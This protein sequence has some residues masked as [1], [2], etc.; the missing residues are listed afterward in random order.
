[1]DF[2]AFADF[3]SQCF[4]FSAVSSFPHFPHS[5]QRERNAEKNAYKITLTEP[6][7][8]MRNIAH[9]FSQCFQSSAVSSFPHFPHSNQRERNGEKNAYK[10][11]LTE[12]LREM[13]N[14]AHKN[15]LNRASCPGASEQWAPCAVHTFIL[16]TSG[17]L[18]GNN[19]VSRM[20]FLHRCYFLLE[21][22]R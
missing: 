18:N 14:I 20:H 16:L 8:E 1:M 10:I 15:I 17:V 22:A 6:L 3:F 21:V 13:R 9:I 2:S 5:N 12:P 7:R 11:T 4:Q 19:L